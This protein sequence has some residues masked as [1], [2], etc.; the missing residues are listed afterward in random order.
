MLYDTYTRVTYVGVH[1]YVHTYVCTCCACV[2][3]L[4]T[5]II[6]VNLVFY[7]MRLESREHVMWIMAH[8]CQIQVYPRIAIHISLHVACMYTCM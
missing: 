2:V 7:R 1:M 6:F 8:L 3:I 5:V 4:H